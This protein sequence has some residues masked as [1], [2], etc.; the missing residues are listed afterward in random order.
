MLR[1]YAQLSGGPPPLPIDVL[2]HG[3]LWAQYPYA[4]MD[5]FDGKRYRHSGTP[6]NVYPYKAAEEVLAAAALEGG[7][8]Q[9]RLGWVWL[10]GT[11]TV[12]GEPKKWC[13][14]A[15][16]VP[17]E[18]S[19]SLFRGK[20]LE[21]TGDM[22][23]TPLIE[24]PPTR[25]RLLE[26]RQFGG[27]AMIDRVVYDQRGSA[28]YMPTDP[29]LLARLEWLQSWI[30]D[31]A[32]ALGVALDD[33]TL[34]RETP[35]RQRRNQPGIGAIV[36]YGLYLDG[37]A[38]QNSARETLR[39]FAE[40]PGLEQTAF[41][42]LFG[43]GIE[44]QPHQYV[45]QMRP[46]S[47]HQKKALHDVGSSSLSLLSGA[48]GTGKTHLLV[49]AAIDAV[50]WGKS[51]LVVS[52]SKHA[53]NVLIDYFLDTPGPTP[54]VFD[55]SARA[56][57]LGY[58]L[59]EYA[60]SER[61]DV[62]ES[63]AVIER[64]SELESQF[65]IVFSL[66]S[67]SN[68]GFE[69]ATLID[70]VFAHEGQLAE[71]FGDVFTTLWLNPLRPTDRSL[72]REIGYAVGS[73]KSAR[74]ESFAEAD[75]ERLAKV[76]PL[77]VGTLEDVERILPK[78]AG[79]FDLI[80][81]DEAAHTNPIDAAG[82]LVRGKHALI[83]GDPTQLGHSSFL[84]GEEIVDAAER[85]GVDPDAINPRRNSLYDLAAAQASATVL[86]EHYRSAPHLIEF[87]ARRF[88]RRALDV[89]TRHPKNDAADHIDVHVVAGE[90]R[91]GTGANKVEVDRCMELVNEFA[92]QGW[93][94]IGLVSPF[95][96]QA[97][98]L[99]AAV[100][101][102]FSL[103]DI[104]RLGLR[105]GTV[106]GFQGDERDV[107]IASWAV[108]PDEP[109][110][111]WQF[112]NQANLF[113]VMVTRARDQMAVVSS[114]EKPPGLAGEYVLWSEPLVDIVTDADVSDP[115]V[116][117]VADAFEDAGVRARTGYRV[118]HH[119]VD[120]V[121]GDGERAVAIDCVLHHEGPEQHLD[122][123]LHLRRMGWQTAEAY[124][125]QWRGRIAEFVVELLTQFPDI[126]E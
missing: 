116:R 99:E 22:E 92:E 120:V 42:K 45:H 33:V 50:A 28:V 7:A 93:T 112:V 110:S 9:L 38:P 55:G 59:A 89:M 94:S 85:N 111:A 82:A 121:A 2:A 95:R 17:V 13:F 5:V 30:A 11:T 88:Y 122:R 34:P 67:E 103:A 43:A 24:H 69:L 65:S 113:N 73:P 29:R 15:L 64:A 96:A 119:I 6:A 108:G 91:N 25:D 100:L 16:S 70:E 107:M 98:A 49:A 52:G 32:Q 58:Q 87:S 104:D 74:L 4:A 35:V 115:W 118:G 60:S 102:K 31:V 19:D 84:S 101:A 26:Q 80:I 124:E 36:C 53:T 10:T 105:V 81:F 126:S 63:K 71:A 78:E 51:V 75:P 117:E 48:P 72:L 83:C 20:G 97:D 44:P 40:K 106:H 1:A 46:F 56:K 68:D 90:R 39:R 79:M 66:A 47:S 14:A 114:V 77:W 27:G 86:D 12:E 21:A 62:T 123:G 76:A 18:R 57:D 109:D 41:A 3:N 61:F 54:V 8:R 37:A 23:M 125:T